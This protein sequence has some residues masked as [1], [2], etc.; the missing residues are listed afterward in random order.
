MGTVWWI[1]ESGGGDVGMV[2]SWASRDGVPLVSV[3]SLCISIS[4]YISTLNLSVSSGG[5]SIEMQGRANR[6]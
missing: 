4:I 3:L 6:V 5:V 1:V 2:D